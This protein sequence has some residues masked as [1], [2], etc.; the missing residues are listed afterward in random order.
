MDPVLRL[1][2]VAE[3]EEA[4]DRGRRLIDAIV[5]TGKRLGLDVVR[6]HPVP[7]GRLD[8]V[9]LWRTD[10]PPLSDLGPLPL[11]AFEVE[12]SWRSRKHVKGSY[13]NLLDVGA[14]LGVII[15]AGEG[16][17]IESLRHF[18]KRLVARPGSRIEIWS[19]ADVESLAEG[20]SLTSNEALVEVNQELVEDAG[21]LETSGG[22]GK[23]AALTRWLAE[24]QVPQLTLSFAEIEEVLGHSLPPSSR[25]YVAHWYG[26]KGSRV[27]RAVIDAGWKASRADLAA[28]RVTLT[29]QR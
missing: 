15:L 4:S 18:A 24:Q 3:H 7:G 8:V 23:Y 22:S 9:W 25:H 1:S 12:S 11:A 17:Q 14:A 21:P 20:R 2:T 27:A 28:E 19:D 13:L 5:L 10:T 29:R 26:Y 6:E 16:A